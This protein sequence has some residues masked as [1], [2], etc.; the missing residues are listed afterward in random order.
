MGGA[1]GILAASRL[2]RLE[3]VVSDSSYADFPRAIA[4]GVWMSYHIPRI[5]LGQM[6]IWAT[7]VRLRCRMSEVSPLFHI[8]GI[9]PRPVLIIQGMQDKTTPPEEG[10]LLYQAAGEPKGVWLVPEAEHVGSFYQL[11]SEYLTRMTDFFDHAF[12]RAA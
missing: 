12:S 6:I 2:P 11:P 10:R 7:A 1:I 8:G 9:A 5:P 4:R 3:A